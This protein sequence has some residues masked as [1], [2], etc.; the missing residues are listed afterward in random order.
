MEIW[1]FFTKYG[2]GFSIPVKQ[3]PEVDKQQSLPSLVESWGTSNNLVGDW[4]REFDE[5][6]KRIEDS[7]AAVQRRTAS[8]SLPNA[9][10][11]CAGTGLHHTVLV[12]PVAF[13]KLLEQRRA[14]RPHRS[15]PS[16]GVQPVGR[17]PLAPGH[18]RPFAGVHLRS[19][20]PASSRWIP[21]VI[22]S[23]LPHATHTEKETYLTQVPLAI[24]HIET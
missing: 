3:T 7:V 21:V 14:D 16:T 6:K 22:C 15:A 24:K 19:H 5:H 20:V 9:T 12:E 1:K 17:R 11:P 4:P 13:S 2:N 18:R 23:Q 10:G 8:R